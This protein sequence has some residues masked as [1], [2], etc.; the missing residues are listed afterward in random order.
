MEGDK[1]VRTLRSGHRSA[2]EEITCLRPVFT[3]RKTEGAHVMSTAVQV[4]H[5]SME[6]RLAQEE[7][8]LV[9]TR[10]VLHQ[11]L[12]QGKAAGDRTGKPDRRY[13]CLSTRQR[14]T[15]GPGAGSRR[16]G[17]PAEPAVP[18]KTARHGV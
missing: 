15:V 18:K 14:L 12:V 3:T 4:A 9:Q 16:S 2:D 11:A 5:S 8:N 13:G 17:A 10:R 6:I 1:T 7:W